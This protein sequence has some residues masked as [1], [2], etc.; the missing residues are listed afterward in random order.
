MSDPQ[1]SGDLDHLLEAAGRRPGEQRLIIVL[2]VVGL[3]L[4][5]VLAAFVVGRGFA[6]RA[7]QD[8]ALPR[9]QGSDA[10]SLAEA[11]VGGGDERSTSPRSGNPSTAPASAAG[12]ATAATGRLVGRPWRKGV[13]AAAVRGV[14]ASCRSAPSVDAGGRRVR[15]GPRNTVDRRPSTAWRCDGN[16][17]GVTLRFRLARPQRIAAVGLVPG[18]AKTDAFNGADR[19]AQNR[20]IARVRWT[21]DDGA[22]VEQTFDT[23]RGVRRIQSKR[24]P[25]VQTRRVTLTIK[26]SSSGRR[27]TV[28]ISA[29]RLAVPRR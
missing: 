3:A 24:I 15:Y 4:A 7:E 29:V 14:T 8:D 28:A 22:W 10:D 9:P 17:R 23:R 2:G 26:D 12:P 11:A 16:G 5:L 25:P 20:R 27:N 6:E 19:Y 1:R 18:Y 13:R 21:F